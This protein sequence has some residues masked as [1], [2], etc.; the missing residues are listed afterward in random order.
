M[1]A[2]CDCYHKLAGTH[3]VIM[4]TYMSACL[5]LVLDRVASVAVYWSRTCWLSW[6]YLS[7]WWQLCCHCCVPQQCQATTTFTC[8]PPC[9]CI[10]ISIVFLFSIFYQSK[11]SCRLCF[12]LLTDTSFM[13]IM[14]LFSVTPL[15]FV[16]ITDLFFVC[17]KSSC[18]AW[19]M[20]CIV[21]GVCEAELIF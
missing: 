1:N 10:L 13:C 9:I 11:M 2:A 12:T 19:F 5:C 20:C 4:M 14:S 17:F 6:C 7:A 21:T 8:T 18:F 15:S 3:T 16:C